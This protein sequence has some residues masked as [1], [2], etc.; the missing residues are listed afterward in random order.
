MITEEVEQAVMNFLAS[1]S[2]ENPITRAYIKNE[3]A[4]R[5]ICPICNKLCLDYVHL[6]THVKTEHKASEIRKNQAEIEYLLDPELD[7]YELYKKSVYKNEELVTIG[8]FFGRIITSPFNQHV[9]LNIIGKTGSGKSTG[10]MYIAEQVAKYVA[11]KL[12][13]KPEDYF[14]ILNIAVMSLDTIIPI[15]KSLDKK[16]YNVFILDDIS[17]EYSARDAMKK[18]NRELNKIISTFRDSNT[19]LVFTTPDAFLI[20]IVGRKLA[21]FQIEMITQVYNRSVSIGKIH[22]LVESYHKNKT[23]YPFPV[24]NGVQYR[25][26]LLRK[27]SPTLTREYL[28]MRSEIRKRST[29]ES[30]K[31]IENGDSGEKK[32]NSK[33]ISFETE[34]PDYIKISPIVAHER[35]LDPK[36][37]IR[38]IAEKLG[39]SKDKVFHSLDYLKMQEHAATA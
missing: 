18:N 23:L 25:R 38:K 24:H 1:S 21:H 39:V 19:M 22:Q 31:S 15:L 33:N 10:S 37:S 4:D 20:D 6:N 7:L 17:G 3:L 14:N 30:I 27:P 11:K 13:G 12:G 28:K 16:R 2:F 35:K 34:V 29:A 36:I 9:L 26:I 8:E 32:S 5:K